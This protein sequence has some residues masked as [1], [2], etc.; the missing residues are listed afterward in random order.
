ML[1]R[2]SS[3]RKNKPG[4][5]AQGPLQRRA[6]LLQGTHQGTT[7]V[8]RRLGP[9]VRCHAEGSEPVTRTLRSY[10]VPQQTQEGDAPVTVTEA[11]L[12]LPGSSIASTSVA[13]SLRGR[14]NAW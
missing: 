3:K 13:L 8:S 1:R 12:M 10:A 6:C 2:K 4:Y 11:P 5:Y 14:G 9:H 7:P